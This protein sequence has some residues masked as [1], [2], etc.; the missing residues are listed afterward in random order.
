MEHFKFHKSLLQGGGGM[1]YDSRYL[2]TENVLIFNIS[3]FHKISKAG[4][5]SGYLEIPTR[6]SLMI[7]DSR[8]I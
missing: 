3:V 8:F 4:K 7:K 5:G 6:C 1:K 2:G